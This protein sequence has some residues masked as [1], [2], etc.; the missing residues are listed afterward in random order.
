[1]AFHHRTI[2]ERLAADIYGDAEINGGIPVIPPPSAPLF[3]GNN[4]WRACV[5]SNSLVP[6]TKVV[7]VLLEFRERR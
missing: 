5:L 4:H 3:S 7:Q 1:M 6:L 2:R